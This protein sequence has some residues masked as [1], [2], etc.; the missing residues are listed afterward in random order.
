M[1]TLGSHIIGIEDSHPDNAGLACL[2][3]GLPPT[4]GGGTLYDL[5]GKTAGATLQGG[6]TWA[7]TPHG[8]SGLAF[9]GGTNAMRAIS[10]SNPNLPVR[11]TDSW[12][13]AFTHRTRSYVSLAQ[14]FG[15]GGALPATGSDGVGR[16]TLSY[17]D[18]YYFWGYNTADFN[19]GVTFHTD[20][21]PH[22]VVWVG[23]GG[24]SQTSISLYVDGVLR[25]AASRSLSDALNYAVVGGGHV[26][27][28]APDAVVWDCSV[29][30][31]AWGASAVARDYE[32]SQDPS[33][34]PRLRRTSTRSLFVTTAGVPS[35]SFVPAFAPGWG[36]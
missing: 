25:A 5:T 11:A 32:W 24:V 29:R 22:R 1:W 14:Y 34:D 16:N 35:Y 3:V 12:T 27:G 28:N 8:Q 30:S 15:F 26:A 36:W 4:D 20:G 21:V 6:A 18:N 23:V 2:L 19:T 33:R 9:A 17:S 31:G 10:A 13:I 7:G